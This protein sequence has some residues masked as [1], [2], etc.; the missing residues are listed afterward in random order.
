MVVVGERWCVCSNAPISELL[1]ID[2]SL[3]R[4]CNVVVCGFVIRSLLL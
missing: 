1:E 3:A 4:I 2:V